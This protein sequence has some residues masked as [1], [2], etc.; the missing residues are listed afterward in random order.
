MKGPM[1]YTKGRNKNVGVEGAGVCVGGTHAHT[2]NEK[3]GKNKN[4]LV[5]GHERKI[6]VLH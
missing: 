6:V 5:P 1:L 3:S 2:E 4:V